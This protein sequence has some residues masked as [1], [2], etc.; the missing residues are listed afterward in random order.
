[1]SFQHNSTHWFSLA[2]DATM[3]TIYLL[4]QAFAYLWLKLIAFIVF[5]PL[6]AYDPTKYNVVMAVLMLV[7][8]DFVSGLYASYKCDQPIVSRKIYR[9]AVKVVVYTFIIASAR[10]TETAGFNFFD[11]D[12]AAAMF[13]ALTE[14]ISILE[15]AGRAGYAIPRKILN[16]L[17]KYRDGEEIIKS[18]IA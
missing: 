12:G 15:N 16:K 8:M 2:T 13:L 17:L 6:L 11:V 9:S 5:I 14:L 10:L 4:K 1:M 3:Y 7:A 18:H